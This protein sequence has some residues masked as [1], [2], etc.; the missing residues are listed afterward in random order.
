MLGSGLKLKNNVK[1]LI[2]TGLYGDMSNMILLKINDFEKGFR[3]TSD[4]TEQ[5]IKIK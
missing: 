1:N 3:L 5:T 4:I 2:M